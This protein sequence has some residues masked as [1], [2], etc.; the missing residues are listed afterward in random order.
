MY[1][2]DKK[3]FEIK[4]KYNPSKC[5]LGETGQREPDS[6]SSTTDSPTD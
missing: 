5:L 2:T 6:T 3:E 1:S 4:V